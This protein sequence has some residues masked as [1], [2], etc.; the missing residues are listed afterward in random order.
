MDGIIVWYVVKR[1]IKTYLNMRLQELRT[2]FIDWSIYISWQFSILGLAMTNQRHGQSA[3]MRPRII[4]I[5]SLK[6]GN[7]QIVAEQYA[8]RIKSSVRRSY[9]WGKINNKKNSTFHHSFLITQIQLIQLKHFLLESRWYISTESSW[10][11]SR[12]S[13]YTRCWEF[14]DRNWSEDDNKIFL[15]TVHNDTISIPEK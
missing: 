9:S 1:T 8:T 10:I 4:Y 15:H 7:I 5:Q 12:T 6:A 11:Y 3:V 2:I 14:L 13:D